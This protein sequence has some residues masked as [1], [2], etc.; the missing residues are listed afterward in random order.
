M[1]RATS[2]IITALLVTLVGCGGGTSP[3]YPTPRALFRAIEDQ[4][5]L[6]KT[7][8]FTLTAQGS[9]PDAVDQGSTHVDGAMRVEQPVASL[10]VK[11]LTQAGGQPSVD[12]EFVSLPEGT[13]V[14]MPTTGGQ[15]P[16]Q[17]KSWLRVSEGG[18]DTI[19]QRFTEMVSGI[20]N[21][22]T[23]A[24]QLARYGDAMT[25]AEASSEPLDGE[26]CTRYELRVD[27]AKT[28]A[29][30][31][32]PTI[33]ETARQ[34]LSHGMRSYEATLWVDDQN[35][36]LRVIVDLGQPGDRYGYSTEVRY[37]D[38]GKPAQINAPPPGQV[39]VAS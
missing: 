8:T 28:D 7:A 5:M 21:I 2:L 19:S 27:L 11:G 9:G 38:W 31:P 35:R 34:L 3:G 36:V 23:P 37:R 22:V 20:R 17:G 4:A 39:A 13:Y 16:P 30:A 10:S 33:R 1:R 26:A 6:D 25:I 14:R 12:L 29:M 18:T 24:S 32:D 15:P